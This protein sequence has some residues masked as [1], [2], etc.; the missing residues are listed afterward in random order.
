LKPKI[1]LLGAYGYTGR[2][3]AQKLS[4]QKISF[5]AAGRD[6]E[7][8]EVLKS[9]LKLKGPLL[10]V[11]TLKA[12]TIEQALDTHDLIINT[13]GPF[14][15]FSRE[16]IRLAAH[17]GKIY[18][19]I[20]GEQAFVMESYEALNAV[21]QQNGATLICS[22]SFESALADFGAAQI[23]SSDQKYHEISSFYEIKATL[24][25]PG[26]RLTMQ[27]APSQKT[28]IYEN[29]VM[30]E[31]SPMAAVAS[32]EE[33]GSVLNAYFIPYPEVFF[34]AKEYQVQNCGTYFVMSDLQ[35]SFLKKGLPQ[36][37]NISEVI[38]KQKT[39]SYTGPDET[40]RSKQAFKIWI[41]AVSANQTKTIK[42]TGYDP[43][44]ITAQIIVESVKAL[45]T[46]KKINYG[47]FSPGQYFGKTLFVK[48]L[49]KELS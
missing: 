29:N 46:A 35:A 18:L 19:D 33:E 21:A 9:T 4:K 26:T 30:V 48:K 16:V 47:F 42:M 5:T 34:F 24:P 2:L 12:E 25:S 23:C 39:S 38:E 11:D 40:A 36:K 1:L 27:I 13:V 7:K 43:Y 10:K 20:T 31:K 22:C 28:Y 37:V 44:G 49:I 6:L 15:Q 8:L 45:M 14:S 17:K 41:K 32:I 3:I